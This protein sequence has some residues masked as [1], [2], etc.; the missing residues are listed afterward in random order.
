[1]SQQCPLTAKANSLL[2][3]IRKSIADRSR[4]V[5]LPLFS[6]LVRSHL[7]RCVQYWASQDRKVWKGRRIGNGVT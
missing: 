2:G 3:C 7:E 5:I 4:E 1:M 6:A